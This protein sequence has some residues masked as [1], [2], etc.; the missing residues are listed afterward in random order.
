M[1]SEQK[2]AYLLLGSNLGDREILLKKAL[3]QLESL[4]QVASV[5]AFYE[6]AAWGKTDQPAFLNCAVKIGCSLT[7]L[8]LLDG[9]L[10]IEAALG[11][12]RHEKWGAR[13]MDIDIIFYGQEIIDLPGRLQVPHPQMALRKFV[14][15]PLA[16]IA[17]DFWHPVL[18]KTVQ[19]ILDELHDTLPVRPWFGG[20]GIK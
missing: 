1:I 7:P 9:I 2:W 17:P 16:E 11:R 12:V 14:L 19:N 8:A 4:G 10:A 3:V 20:E 6:T 13:L 5:S 15:M 18:H